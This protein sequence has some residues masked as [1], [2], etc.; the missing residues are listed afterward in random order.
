[1]KAKVAGIILITAWLWAPGRAQKPPPLKLLHADRLESYQYHGQTV[2]RLVGHVKLSRQGFVLTCRAAEHNLD[3][4]EVRLSGQVHLFNDT[5]DMRAKYAFY[6][7]KNEM[8]RLVGDVRYQ[9]RNK[10][11]R[12]QKILYFVHSRTAIATGTPFLQ[13][14]ARSLQADTIQYEERLGLGVAWPRAVLVDS[15]ARNLIRG[16]TIRFWY[17]QDSLVAAPQGALVK[18]DSTGD[19]LFSLAADTLMLQSELFQARGHA[20]FQRQD[21]RITCGQVDYLPSQK[22]AYLRQQPLLRQ[23][24]YRLSGERFILH[25]THEQVDRVTVPAEALFIQLKSWQDSLFQDRLRGQRMEIFL[26]HGQARLVKIQGMASSRFHA[27]EDSVYQGLNIVSGDSILIALNDSTITEVRIIGATQ[28]KF[29]PSRAAELKGPVQYQ[30]GQIIY[31]LQREHSALLNNARIKYQDMELSAGRIDVLWRKNL[32]QATPLDD[33]TDSGP[34]FTQTGQAP[35]K[36]REMVYDLRTERG[37]VLAG[38]S[39]YQEGH[40]YGHSMAR[41]NAQV[42]Q[43]EQ[44]YY[45]TCDLEPDPHYY[46]YSSHMKLLQDH[47][48]IARPLWLYIADVPLLYLPFAILPQHHGR[49][50]GFLIP[51]YDYVATHGRALKGFG[52]YWAPS[53]YFAAKFIVDFYDGERYTDT[54]GVLRRAPILQYRTIMN[55]KIRYRLSGQVRGTLTP[56]WQNGRRIYRWSFAFQHN[57]TFNP[58]LSVNASGRLYGDAHFEQDFNSNQDTRLNKKLRS[59]VTLSKRWPEWK[60]SLTANATYDQD[61]QV[62]EKI[63]LPPSKEGVQLQGPTLLLPH[64][65]FSRQSSALFPASGMKLHWYNRLRWNYRSAFSN[66]IKV[67][68]NSQQDSSGELVWVKHRQNDKVWTHSATLSGSYNLLGVLNASASLTGNSGIIFQYALPVTDSTGRVVVDSMGKIV[69]HEQRGWLG[70]VL[71]SLSVGLSTK[72]YGLFPLEV[73]PLQAIRHVVTPSLSISYSPSFAKPGWGYV[74]RYRDSSGNEI[75]YDPFKNSPLGNTPARKVLNL[76]FKIGNEFDYKWGTG[77]QVQKGKLLTWSMSGN[78]NAAADSL[79]LSNISNSFRFYLGKFLNLDLRSKVDLYEHD[80]S[81]AKIDR[82]SRPRI[83]SQSLNFGFKLTGHGWKP[84]TAQDS[85]ADTAAVGDFGLG[86]SSRLSPG[87]VTGGELWQASFS[88]AYNF[89]HTNPFAKAAKSFWLNTVLDLRP[90]RSWKVRYSARFDLLKHRLVS[91]NLSLNRD[92]HCWTLQFNWQP[93]GRYSSW[94]ITIR[95]K[96]PHLR[97]LKIKHTSRA[98]RL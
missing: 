54:S 83:S 92:L 38:K 95:V 73:G 52:Y 30:A 70:R 34:V 82:F 78:Y 45:T 47:W 24:S 62:G 91:H 15:M 77:K 72:L 94:N 39:K 53:D 96:A 22:V 79:R 40:Y 23:G 5:T 75:T 13:D 68:Y 57:Q 44:G 8:A 2:R 7:L 59:A 3:R 17:R 36:G 93:S 32:L 87:D 74:R 65:S 42:Y 90:T 11:L 80:S 76:S 4:G 48:L 98:F 86:Q 66:P 97:D 69:T 26:E 31:D 63:L 25:F 10:L 28:G 55:Y 6:S 41:I 21:S 16:Q 20:L 58:T 60:S 19:T 37:K 14:S 85:T 51:S 49:S 29:L 81:G 56:D 1:M 61:L 71:G 88:L 67:T 9:H 89:N 50:S 43:V 27:V 64:L 12:A 46:F 35:F 33:S 18:W 84:Q